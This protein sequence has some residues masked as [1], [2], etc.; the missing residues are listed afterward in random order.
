LNPITVLVSWLVGC[1]LGLFL[2]GAYPRGLHTGYAIAFLALATVTALAALIVRKDH[3]L[4]LLS[5]LA[6]VTLAGVGRTLL[7]NPPVT[8]RDLAFYNGT[9]NS[10]KVLVVGKI[11][12]EPQ[13]TDRSQRVRI[14]AE[15]IRLPGEVVPRA[16]KGD[17]LAVVARYPEFEVGGQ[18]ALSGT[19]TAPP[20][21]DTFDYAGYLARQGV[22]SYMLFPRASSFGT[23]TDEGWLDRARDWVRDTLRRGLPEPYAALAV[24]IVTGDRTSIRDD[25]KRAFRRSGTSHILAISGQNI[26]L[27]VGVVYL[28]YGRNSKRRLGWPV[29]LAVVVLLA[30]YTLFTG[31]TPSV[32]RASAMGALLLLAPVVRRRADP[33][34]ALAIA[35]AVMIMLDPDVMADVGFQLSFAAM[36]GIAFL[37]PH[38]YDGLRRVKV[39]TLLAL[40]VAVSLA[41][42]LATLPLVVAYSGELSVVSTPATLSADLG[43]LPIMVT[44]ILTGILGIVGSVFPPLISVLGALTWPF[45]A[46]L[47]WWVE[48]WGGLPWAAF[49][50]GRLHVAWVVVYYVALGLVVWLLDRRR[51]ARLYSS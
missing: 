5:V 48:F 1:A 50:V 16:V 3:Y 43:L 6:A 27:L 38:L 21:L 22:Y 17:V 19:L 20:R 47:L 46:W 12:A 23:G 18:V 2:A 40:P 36:L 29:L 11:A 39:P 30:L 44:G 24:G 13:L 15:G 33:V 45:T 8:D 32:V 10:P 26:M 28:F 41:A 35:G 31:G 14:A 49:E 25:V 9:D 7:T 51:L 4:L 37:A 42:Q 34:A